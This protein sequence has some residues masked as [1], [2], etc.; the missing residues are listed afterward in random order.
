[1]TLTLVVLIASALVSSIISGIIGMG[2]GVLLLAVMA[3]L[4]EP[5]V[6]VPVHGIVQLVSNGTRVFRLL[7]DV[8]LRF[9]AYY[10]PGLGVG[11]WLG[12]QL[13]TGQGVA[14]FKP[15][16]GAFV[17]AFLLWERVKPK[18]LVVPMWLL[19]PGGIGGGLLTVMVGATGPY[20]AAFLLRDDL[21]RR[22]IVAT[23]AAVQAVGHFAKIPAFL[24]V[25]F[26]Y[27]S[28]LHVL[29]P[30][31]ACAIVGTFVGTSILTRMP[32][33]AF[34]VAFRVVLAL[35]GVRLLASGF[36]G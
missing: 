5:I 33:R 28:H 31:V 25:G 2:G 10:V 1:M 15:V 22:K 23:K 32:E 8:D 16:V 17:L 6:V 34:R 13:Y 7:R 30:L 9:F 4:L 19:I 27:T 26:D 21:E 35:L 29:L 3:S 12:I 36:L 14:W 18:R 20:L 11:A 24:S